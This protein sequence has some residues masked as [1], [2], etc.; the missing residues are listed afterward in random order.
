MRVVQLILAVLTLLM[1]IGS[2]G[3]SLW[4][5]SNFSKAVA[6]PE[7]YMPIS[8]ITAVLVLLT[9]ITIFIRK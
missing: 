2:F 3:M 1:A 7:C 5:K 6:V 4:I 9:V 8:I